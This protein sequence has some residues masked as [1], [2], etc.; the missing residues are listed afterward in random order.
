MSSTKKLPQ[1]KCVGCQNTFQKR[2]LI[3]IVK[4][5][6][7]IFVDPTGKR[8]G[9]GAYICKNLQCLETAY[10]RKNLER[11]FQCRVDENVYKSLRE[12][13]SGLEERTSD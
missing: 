13:L 5:E 12:E 8:N 3:R 10:K 2:E 7:G 9:R 11:S 6:D 1:R 4:G